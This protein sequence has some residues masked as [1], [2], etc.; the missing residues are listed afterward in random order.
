MTC[1]FRSLG[2]VSAGFWIRTSCLTQVLPEFAPTLWST[3]S[4]DSFARHALTRWW[5]KPFNRLILFAQALQF[6][7]LALPVDV[8]ILVHVPPP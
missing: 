8:S 5:T 2:H 4:F 3:R 7:K 6:N 1:K